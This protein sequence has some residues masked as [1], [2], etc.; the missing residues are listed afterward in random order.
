MLR[1]AVILVAFALIAVLHLFFVI[2]TS[3]GQETRWRIEGLN[4]GPAHVNYVKHLVDR[5]QF[6]IAS[7]TARDPDAFTRNEFEYYQPPLYYLVCCRGSGRRR[8]TSGAGLPDRLFSFRDAAP[9]GAP[10]DRS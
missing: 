9:R 5:H 4:D 1:K 10:A 7:T 3:F 2:A 6:P 8:E